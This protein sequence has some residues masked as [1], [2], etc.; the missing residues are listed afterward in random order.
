MCELESMK[1][2][3]NCMHDSVMCNL[4]CSQ[5]ASIRCVHESVVCYHDTVCVILH[6]KDCMK[7][8]FGTSRNSFSSSL[9]DSR[10]DIPEIH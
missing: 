8:Y 9:A 10:L 4:I 5:H 3:P 2:L 7:L 6:S 1:L